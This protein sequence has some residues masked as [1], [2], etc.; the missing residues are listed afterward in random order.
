MVKKMLPALS[1][2]FFTLLVSSP[3]ARAAVVSNIDVPVP[4]FTV[5]NVCDGE[6]VSIDAD[7]AHILV[8]ITVNDNRALADVQVNG[9][10]HG[11][12][13]SGANY[14]LVLNAKLQL[15]LPLTNGAAEFMFTLNARLVGQGPSNNVYVKLLLKVGIDANGNVVVTINNSSATCSNG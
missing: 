4:A 2:M 14:V 5:L 1:L 15:N 7:T 9:N 8:A 6:T 13:T 12:G 11:T 3:S 10:F